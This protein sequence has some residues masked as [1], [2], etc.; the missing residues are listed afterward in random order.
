MGGSDLISQARGDGDAPSAADSQIRGPQRV[1][2]PR[3]RPDVR[4]GPRSGGRAGHRDRHAGQLVDGLRQLTRGVPPRDGG[5][6]ALRQVGRAA[7]PG[8][9]RARPDPGRLAVRVQLRVL[10]ALQVVPQAG[11]IRGEDQGHPG[12]GR[13]RPV[14]PAGAGRAGHDRRDRGRPRPGR[15]RGL[16]RAQ[17]ASDRRADPRP[18]LHHGHVR[19]ARHAEPGAADRVRR[20]GRA[21]AGDRRARG[22][23]NHG[24]VRR[25][26]RRRE[27]TRRG[28]PVRCRTG[29]PPSPPGRSPRAARRGPRRCAR[30]S[31]ARPARRPRPRL[32]CG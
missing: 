23:G 12:L 10:P 21:G 18:D 2:A 5:V 26:V 4:P 32:R 27:L 30:S 19:H 17:G 20:Q 24:P 6:R 31:A 28:R 1:R 3:L 15:R 9:P 14:Q 22:R 8:A 25:P 7:G 16:R 29:P 11:H 13:V